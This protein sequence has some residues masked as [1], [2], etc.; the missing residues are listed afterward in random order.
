M[1]KLNNKTTVQNKMKKICLFF[2]AAATMILASCT[3]DEL[4]NVNTVPQVNNNPAIN[5]T[6][7]SNQVTRADV[8]GA[9][10]ATLL[11]NTFRVYGVTKS[12]DVETP[13]F[14]N[15]VVNYNGNVGS[16]STN[17]NGWTYLGFESKGL[18]PATQAVKYWDLDMPEYDFVAFAG[19]ADDNR[20]T[21]TTTNTFPVD[22]TNLG[23]IFVSD[24]VTAKYKASATGETSN[25][26]YGH[27]INLTF[28]RLAARVRLGIYETVPGYAVKDV[29]FYY[30][31]NYLA[32]RGT[33]TKTNAGLRGTF[34]V[35]GNITVSYDANNRVVADFEGTDVSDN[36]QF[37]ELEYT[38]AASNL[39]SGGYMKE[40]GSVDATGDACFLSTTSALPTYAKKDAVIDGASVSNSAWQPVVPFASNATNL[41]LTV[42]FTLVSLDGVGAPI[43]VKG[44]SAVVPVSYALWKPNYAYTYIFKIS[45]KTNGTTGSNPNP[46]DPDNPNPNPNPGVD[47]GLYPITFDASVSSVEDYKQETITGVTGLGG[48]AITTYSPTSDVTNAGEYKVGEE[49]TVSSISHG[50]WKVAYSATEP[51]EQSV[52]DNNTYT[53][54]SIGGTPEAGQTIDE[55]GTTW[56]KFTVE[57]V[58][59]YIVWLRYLPTGLEDA[60]GNYVN[61]FKV[62]KTVE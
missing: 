59:Y 20:I 54:T 17:T 48:D 7:G 2:A 58:G 51:T 3:S 28:K 27:T 38:V 45:D 47:L 6:G 57:K 12:G 33:S 50:E 14:D 11:N 46:V 9:D 30:G 26:Q 15:F 22:Q 55:A 62:V 53:Y 21:G 25:A 1:I 39:T 32:S 23:K 31:D 18:N 37:G 24:R 19:L 52:T 44:A 10:A 35:S 41:V 49:V 36:F 5:F 40:D 13:V 56:A 43:H 4:V 60:P 29:K 16:D 42:D 8:T 61:I 34:P